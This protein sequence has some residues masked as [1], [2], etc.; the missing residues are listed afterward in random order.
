MKLFCV[1]QV[2]GLSKKFGQTPDWLIDIR[3]WGY[4]VVDLS[5]IEIIYSIIPEIFFLIDFDVQPIA[6]DFLP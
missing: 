3:S 1:S 2:F 5:L 4:F 6:G